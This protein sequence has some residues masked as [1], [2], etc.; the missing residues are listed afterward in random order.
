MDLFHPPTNYTHFT[1]KIFLK[2][3]VLHRAG[4][5]KCRHLLTHEF[6]YDIQL[7]VESHYLSL[8]CYHPIFFTPIHS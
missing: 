7:L 8:P 3:Q 6:S 5:F 1:L 4:K 2:P